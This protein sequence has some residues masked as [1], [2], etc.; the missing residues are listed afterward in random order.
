MS[1]DELREWQAFD[2][3]NPIGDYRMDLNFAL[4]AQ[5]II[6]WSG[7]CKEAPSIKDLL[8]ID[9]FPLTNEQR[10]IETAKADAERSQAYTES[11]IATLKRRAKK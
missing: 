3:V 2:S 7:H 4:L 5:K 11:L 6:S 1:I 10:A 8:V 9:P